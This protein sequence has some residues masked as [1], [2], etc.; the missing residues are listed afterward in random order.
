MKDLFYHIQEP[1]SKYASWL[2]PNL[3]VDHILFPGYIRAITH[4]ALLNKADI[5]QLIFYSVTRDSLCKDDWDRLVELLLSAEPVPY[6]KRAA[7][8]AFSQFTSIDVHRNGVLFFEDFM[9]ITA[10]YP[11]LIQ[12][13]VRLTTSIRKHHL[14]ESF[15]RAKRAEIERAYAIANNDIKG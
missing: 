3:D 13:F 7:I 9:K 5:L 12:P 6:P 10:H 8:E 11:F 15:W 4:A 14:G 2:F 1:K